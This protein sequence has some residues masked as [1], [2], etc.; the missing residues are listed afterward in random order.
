MSPRDVREVR[1][2]FDV[3]DDL[4]VRS[5]DPEEGGEVVHRVERVARRLSPEEIP[6][7][8]R[9]S[10]PPP[11]EVSELLHCRGPAVISLTGMGFWARF[12]R[13]DPQHGPGAIAVS[14]RLLTED[15][16]NEIY[17]SDPEWTWDV[18][19]LLRH[20]FRVSVV[21]N[22]LTRS[23]YVVPLFGQ[24]KEGTTASNAS[25]YWL[26]TPPNLGATRFN[27]FTP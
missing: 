10:P 26:V 15:E 13:N 20:Q 17:V 14:N 21:A 23:D 22:L 19:G 12:E 9:S 5:A 24:M 1:I 4:P 11:S 18:P 2:V 8:D 3:S 16:P 6:V 25:R 7:E 27:P